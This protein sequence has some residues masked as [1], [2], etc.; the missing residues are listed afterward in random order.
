MTDKTLEGVR[1]AILAT[2]GVEQSELTE[3]RFALEQAG[4]R[5]WLISLEPGKIQAISTTRRLISSRWIL[6][7]MRRILLISTPFYSRG[8]R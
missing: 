1:V 7:A 8:A 3:P 4:A 6:P 2:N 5:A